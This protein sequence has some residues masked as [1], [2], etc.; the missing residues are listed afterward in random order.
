LVDRVYASAAWRRGWKSQVIQTPDGQPYS[1]YGGFTNFASPTVR[2]YNVDIATAAAKLGIDDVLY[3]YVRRPDGPIS[4]MR[5][6][7]LSGTPERSIST[8]LGDARR[9]L[10]PYGT[11]LG[12]SVFG[13]AATRPTEVAQDIPQIGQN[14]DYV[15]P[16]VSPSHWAP[17]EYNVS[18]PNAEP[19]Q[20]VRRSLLDFQKDARG[21]GARV[22]PWLQDF[23]LGVTYGPKQVCDQVHAAKSDG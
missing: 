4:T 14:V 12:A 10:K 20:I 13:V 23:S 22:V 9:A 1:G 21:T 3:D 2:E 19:Y 16:M 7:G 6:P 11:F 18:Y 8:F 15:A 5:F 17:G